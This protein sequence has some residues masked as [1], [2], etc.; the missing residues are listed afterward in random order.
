MTNELRGKIYAVCCMV[1]EALDEETYPATRSHAREILAA[2]DAEPEDR[3][4]PSPTLTSLPS[5]WILDD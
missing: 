4:S 1:L 5:V 2:L 3:P